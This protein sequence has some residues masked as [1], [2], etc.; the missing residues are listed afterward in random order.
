[1][2]SEE[3]TK[4]SLSPKRQRL[5]EVMQSV[6]FGRIEHL[7]VR[8]G[9]PTFEPRPTV[10]RHI[11]LGADS[12]LR[13]ETALNDFQ[14]KGEVREMFEHLTRIGNGS[15]RCIEVKYGL[16]FSMTLEDAA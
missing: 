14:L 6:G 9:E 3:V 15:V 5:V 7:S 2:S 11:K 4:R 10:I 16:P 12:A 8:S 13:P 1:M